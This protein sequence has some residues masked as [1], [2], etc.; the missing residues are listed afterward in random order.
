MLLHI[1][2]DS[3]TTTVTEGLSDI[4]ILLDLKVQESASLVFK[5]TKCGKIRLVSV[6][7]HYLGI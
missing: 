5:M 3:E 2:N 7:V 1:T 4:W 6:C